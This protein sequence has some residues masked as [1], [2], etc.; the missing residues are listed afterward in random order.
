MTA[1]NRGLGKGFGSLLPDNY[2]NS[3]LLDKG[4]RIQK[5]LIQDIKPDPNQPRK[6]FDVV[7]I[8]EL[9]DSIKQYGILQ[10]L[11]ITESNNSGYVIIAGERRFRAAKKAGLTHVPA[12]VRTLEDLERL[13]IGLIENV[14]RVDLTPLE[15]ALSIAR[16]NEQFSMTF[17]DIAKRL[18]KAHT[19]VVNT[20][21]LLQLP[22]FAR[23]ALEDG[24]ISEG[25]ARAVLALKESEPSQK[26]LVEKIV[27]DGWSVRQAE[28]YV[29]S[30]KSQDLSK[31]TSTRKQN[32]KYIDQEKTLSGSVGA[33]ANITQKGK[34][35]EVK[36]LFDSNTKF[37]Q[38][39]KNQ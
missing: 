38:F 9:A 2:D 36:L 19:T 7:T 4:E 26:Y 11:V 6:S 37:D 39:L 30:Q 32:T 5:V 16:L 1:K 29:K 24:K 14:Q 21:R 33:K 34:K 31:K 25:H 27:K 18:G 28:N 12:L 35:I 23:K 20:A 3:V 15:Q 10:P 22:E 17:Q 13:E 8:N